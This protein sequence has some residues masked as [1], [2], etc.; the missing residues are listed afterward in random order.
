[1][2]AAEVEHAHLRP[3]VQQ[4]PDQFGGGRAGGTGAGQ[5]GAVRREPALASLAVTGVAGEEV[6]IVVVVHGG[7]VEE[8]AH[9]GEAYGR[10]SCS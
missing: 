2:P 10:R 3:Q 4:L 5:V 6:Q 1:V 8:V 9:A 7:G